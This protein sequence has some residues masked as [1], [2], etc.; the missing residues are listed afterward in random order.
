MNSLNYD[1][2]YYLFNQKPNYKLYIIQDGIIDGQNINELEYFISKSLL[3]NFYLDRS[4]IEDNV[5]KKLYNLNQ[6]KNT[7]I[8]DILRNIEYIDDNNFYE[9]KIKKKLIQI[10]LN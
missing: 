10:F 6:F 9:T 4:K 1:D 8:R 2:K 7:E 5:T 3:N